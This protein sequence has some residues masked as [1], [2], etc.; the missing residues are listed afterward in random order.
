MGDLHYEFILYALPQ[1]E[2]NFAFFSGSPFL[3]HLAVELPLLAIRMTW[4]SRVSRDTPGHRTKGNPGRTCKASRAPLPSPP[5]Q[6]TFSQ[7]LPS[8]HI[9]INSSCISN[10]KSKGA[11]YL[12]SLIYSAKTKVCICGSILS[13]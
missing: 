8:I 10:Q 6:K 3:R 13:R 11:P 9:F 5:A 4:V 12:N 1:C 2:T 7:G